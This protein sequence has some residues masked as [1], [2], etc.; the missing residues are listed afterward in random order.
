MK[1]RTTL[2]AALLSAAFT[3]GALAATDTFKADLK[4]SQEVPPNDSKGTGA[5]E[6]SYDPATKTLSWK[7]TYSGL[8]GQ[9][10]AAH[11]HG[12]AERG[13]DAP[14]MIKLENPASPIQGSAKLTDAQAKALAAGKL[15]INVHTVEHKSG[16]I[17]GQ[18]EPA[19]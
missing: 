2:A 7:V 3:A 17:R 10:T 8:S 14:P 16:E 1:I 11:I 6:L 15:Y 5:A 13:K 9:A 19:K 4:G 12:P 18:V